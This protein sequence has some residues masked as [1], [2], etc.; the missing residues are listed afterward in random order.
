MPA[1][2]RPRNPKTDPNVSADGSNN[3]QTADV[4]T[5][6]QQAIIDLLNANNAT[7][8]NGSSNSRN[9]STDSNTSVGI[10]PKE[11]AY[12]QLDQ[13]MIKLFGRR[14][15]TIEKSTY[16]KSLNTA[17]KHYATVTN[18]SSN[19][20]P[21]KAG[22]ADI[23][24]GS[25]SSTNYLFDSSSFL[26]EFTANLAS[27]YIKE[28]KTLG[29]VAGQ[30]YDNLKTYA[31]SMGLSNDDKSIIKSTIGIMKGTTDETS[32]KNAYRKR[33][34][35]L[36]GSLAENLKAD[37]TLTVRDAATDYI[38]I[39]SNMLDINTGNISL[40]DPTLSKALNAT[41]KD[42]K[43]YVMNLNEFTSNLR[44]D[45][46]FQFSTTAH[47]E[48]RTLASSFASAFGFGG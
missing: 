6:E 19:S 4:T 45:S 34:I 13:T 9:H 42:G 31:T 35:S 11:S 17:E 43:P 14:A 5:P 48:A 25:S 40:H 47:E 27:N 29:G 12:S 8:G 28:G 26:F 39:M 21:N 3:G 38:N 30:T 22:D 20:H 2:T 23:S 46:R 41:N 7:N 18:S 32:I 10:T 33:A 36:Y 44:D 37:P 15:T 24:V 16:Y 1:L